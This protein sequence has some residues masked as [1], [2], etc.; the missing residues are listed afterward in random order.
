VTYLKNM[1]NHRQLTHDE[2]KASEAA[3][4]GLPFNPEWSNAAKTVYEGIV[5]ALGHTNFEP[6]EQ[7]FDNLASSEGGSPPEEISEATDRPS[8]LAAEQ[9]N[10]PAVA[11]TKDSPLLQSRKEA[12]TAGIL[13]DATPA[14]QRIGLHLPVGLTNALW[15]EYVAIDKDMTDEHI[16]SRLRDIMLGVR[17]R[18]AS[19]KDSVPFIDIPILLNFPPEPI[20]Q[21]SLTFALFHRDPDEGH[22]LLL[23][24][25][26]EIFSSR[27]N[28]EQN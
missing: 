4:H 2:K 28:I 7:I 8:P 26:G 13:R 3:F 25:P 9:T 24:H 20:P 17:L 11:L 18:L 15:E 1:S 22:C 10:D 12:I 23:I 21:I 27:Q 6:P 16:Q 5:Q 14:A 19:L